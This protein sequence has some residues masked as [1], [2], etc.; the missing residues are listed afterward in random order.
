MRILLLLAAVV[1]A[2]PRPIAAQLSADER[3]VAETLAQMM[4]DHPPRSGFSSVFVVA[5]GTPFDS[6][7]AR[8]LARRFPMMS[9]AHADRPSIG[10][11]GVTIQGDTATAYW[12]ASSG[13]E[14]GAEVGDVITTRILFVR[15]QGSWRFLR[16]EYFDAATF[17]RVRG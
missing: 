16:S 6:A 13:F 8:A 9:A 17:G 14:P 2:G 3:E 1:L 4:F 7:V 15:Q 5:R 11:R 12:V 10:T